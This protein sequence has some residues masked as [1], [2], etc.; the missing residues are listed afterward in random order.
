MFNI[1]CGLKNKL[2][3]SSGTN[4]YISFII[5]YDTFCYKRNT[6]NISAYQKYNLFNV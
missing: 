1:I 5:L 3:M 2:L 6:L 4:R